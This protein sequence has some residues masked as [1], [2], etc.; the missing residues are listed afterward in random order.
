MSSAGITPLPS[1]LFTFLKPIRESKSQHRA[2]SGVL[3]RRPRQLLR[4]H[5]VHN[6]APAHRQDGQ[7][8]IAQPVRLLVTALQPD[9][10]VRADLAGVE[11]HAVIA[12]GVP[13]SLTRRPQAAHPFQQLL[14]RVPQVPG[15]DHQ[16]VDLQH[17]LA[18]R[19]LVR[20]GLDVHAHALGRA[21][22]LD[23][24]DV[25][26]RQDAV[27]PLRL[28]RVLHALQVHRVVDL[29]DQLEPDDG[30]VGCFFDGDALAALFGGLAEEVVHALGVEDFIH[31]AFLPLANC[32][33]TLSGLLRE[34]LQRRVV[35]GPEGRVPEDQGSA[36]VG[37]PPLQVVEDLGG[38]LA[39]AHDGDVVGLGLVL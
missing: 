25:A 17:L 11:R 22:V 33:D 8:T 27:L 9:T 2:Q 28:V 37:I 29:F 14:V 34:Y 26:L 21:V 7:E 20:G 36:R 4:K 18:L 24:A 23:A 31:A 39:A 3:P 15:G 13:R 12:A 16:G 30:V 35:A 19:A 1:H 38:A 10:S 32:P 5:R 6:L